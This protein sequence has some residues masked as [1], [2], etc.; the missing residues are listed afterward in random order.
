MKTDQA[1]DILRYFKDELSY[2]RGMGRSFAEHYPKLANRLE[3]SAHGCADPQV[4][5]LIESFAFLTARIQRKLDN[6][7]PEITNALLGVLY[8]HLVNPLPPAAIAKFDVDP[9]RGKLTTGFTLAKHTPVFAQTSQGLT[10]RFRTCYPVTLWP[11][12]V[13]FAGFE[14]L[15]ESA[16][17]FK[18]LPH[19]SRVASV[20]RLRLVAAGTPFREMELHRLRFYLHGAF[21][22]VDTLYELLFD[23]VEGVV[24]CPD[25]DRQPS[26]LSRESILPVGFGPGEEVIPYPDH[27]HPAY[28]LLQEYFFFQ[29]KFHFLDL[30]GLD[31]TQCDTVMDIRVLLNV[32]PSGK[33]MV[34]RS[35]F[36]L[37]C[38]PVVNLFRKSAEPIRLDHRQ[39]EYRL[40]P[41]MRR[42]RTT[43][44]HSITSVSASSNPLEADQVLEPFYS[45]RHKFD[46][47]EPVA[48]WHARREPSD[49]KDL[50]GTE[51]FLSFVDLNFNPSLPPHQTIFAHT[52]CMN[53]DLALELPVR[54]ILQLEQAAPVSSAYLLGKPTPTAYPPL[55]GATLWALISNLSMNHLSLSGGKEGLDALKEILSLYGFPHRHSTRQ[56]IEGIKEMSCRR[57]TRRVGTEAWRGFCH[58]TEVTLVLDEEM[59]VG[60]GAFLLGAVLQRFL[61]LYGSINSFTQLVIRK[62]RLEGEWKKF[63]PMLGAKPML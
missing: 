46:G 59:Y 14:S 10:C 33:T 31:A 3:L 36:C 55:E 27:A 34:D 43:E 56:Q 42:V 62:W 21:T 63:P 41:D 19:P 40:V 37:G 11:L 16:R 35:T 13:A 23:Q 29:H 44:I 18:V 51:M 61:S 38:T 30:D 9:D 49:R 26:F 6:Q 2:L 20:L 12:D 45:F 8:P 28:R 7:F 57:V 52:L 22:T 17:W 53:R 24:I 25:N 4:E 47:E 58:G 54:A 32:T 48:F 15:D 39:S 50:P 1:E 5:R 60:G